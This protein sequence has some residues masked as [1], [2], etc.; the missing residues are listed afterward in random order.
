MSLDFFKDDGVFLP[1]LNDQ[2]RNAFYRQAIGLAAPGRT[3]CDIGAGTGLLSIMA[4]QS[5]ASKVIAVERDPLRCNYLKDILSRTG[6]SN[7]VEVVEGEFLNTDINADVYVSETINT[8]IF[9]EDMLKLSNHVCQRGGTFIPGSVRIWA[10]AYENH[11]VF[12][13]D[14]SR[15]EAYDFSPSVNVDS[16]FVAAINQDFSQQNELKD[17]V[18]RANQLNR[19]FTMLDRFTDLKLKKLYQTKPVVVDFNRFNTESDIAITIPNPN[20]ALSNAMIVLKWQMCYQ[21]VVLD[22]DRCWFGNVAKGIN[23][24][25]STRSEIEF[26]YDPELHD[27]RLTY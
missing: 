20:H 15:S 26:R 11:P 9:G 3:V 5:G 21:N 23:K 14:L 7:R 10:E 24:K 18:F 25:F 16:N 19:L 12:I 13:L 8:Q 27:W 2:G 1:M 6:Y 4:V 22:S 17:T